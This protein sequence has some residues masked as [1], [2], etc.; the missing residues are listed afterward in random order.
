MAEHS[1]Q[2]GL[3]HKV[4]LENTQQ[5]LAHQKVQAEE[6]VECTI[7]KVA[8]GGCSNPKR[9]AILSNIGDLLV[10]NTFN[11]ISQVTEHMVF[12]G[13]DC[14]SFE[15]WE[16][17]WLDALFG[18]LVCFFIEVFEVCSHLFTVPLRAV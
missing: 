16:S 8:T 2:K 3:R 4:L 17:E 15:R 12:T 10:N 18:K 6:I 1:N 13:D 5:K 9:E 11:T 7:T 14:S